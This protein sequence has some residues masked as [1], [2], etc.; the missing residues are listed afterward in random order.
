MSKALECYSFF[1]ISMPRLLCA[2][3]IV[4]L[5][6]GMVCMK[7][8]DSAP[9]APQMQLGHFSTFSSEVDGLKGKFP[10]Q[11]GLFWKTIKACARHLFDSDEAT[12][13]AVL[14]MVGEK[15]HAAEAALLARDVGRRFENNLRSNQP[16]QPQAIA[17]L[18]LTTS[19]GRVGAGEQK[20]FLDNWLNEKLNNGHSAVIL[21]HLEVLSP[22]AALLLH[23]YCDGDNAPY[24]H[25]MLVLGLYFDRRMDSPQAAESALRNLWLPQLS[26]DK[27]GALLSR[28]AN[29][30]V[31]WASPPP[32]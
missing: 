28:V 5:L 17:S 30:I 16:P 11:D 22:E 20:L 21:N 15:S 26:E 7:L 4:I 14:L 13:P 25:A 6:I 9:R 10:E 23:G 19:P 27:V 18:N 3:T 1:G 12:Y 24:K 31:L 8:S 29:N 32:K 2:L